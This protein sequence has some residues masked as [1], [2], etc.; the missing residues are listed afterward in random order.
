MRA[1]KFIGGHVIF[2]LRYN[3]IYQLKTTSN[4]DFLKIEYSFQFKVP[5]NDCTANFIYTLNFFL[6]TQHFHNSQNFDFCQ[7]IV[8][9]I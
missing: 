9:H 5:D 6:L 4:T 7:K 1:L 2:K 3:L 8:K